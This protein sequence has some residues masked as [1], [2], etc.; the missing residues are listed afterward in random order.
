MMINSEKM[1]LY[2]FFRS[3]GVLMNLQGQTQVDVVHGRYTGDRMNEGYKVGDRY[4]VK[5]VRVEGSCKGSVVFPEML[6]I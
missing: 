5:R 2:T 6:L 3:L 4:K 1:C